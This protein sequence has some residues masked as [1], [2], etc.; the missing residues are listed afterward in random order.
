[1]GRYV[2]CSSC[3]GMCLCVGRCKILIRSIGKTRESPPLGAKSRSMLG[4][5][6]AKPPALTSAVL[7]YLAASASRF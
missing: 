2:Y 4:T 5:A 6:I 7:L 3:N 1:M